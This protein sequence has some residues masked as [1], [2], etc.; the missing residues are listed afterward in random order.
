MTG[1]KG[2]SFGWERG[3]VRRYPRSEHHEST[4]MGRR[5]VVDDSDFW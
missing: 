4:L 1:R 5:K 2:P 3:A